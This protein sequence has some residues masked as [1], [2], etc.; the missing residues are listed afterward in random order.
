MVSWVTV[1]D[2]QATLGLPPATQLDA[3]YLQDCVD[4]A[5]DLA[6][7]RRHTAGYIDSL[8][9]AP[10]AAVKLGTARCAVVLYRERGG[11]DAAASFEELGIGNTTLFSWSE[12]L[13]LWGCG[14]PA[15][16]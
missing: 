11:V 1:A 4:A 12:V 3:D 9:A 2:V 6:W 16:G 8:D 5:N 14:R 7:R 13:R 15:T 10:D